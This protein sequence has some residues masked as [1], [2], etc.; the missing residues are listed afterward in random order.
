MPP[1]PAP[2][3]TAPP[4]DAA[5]AGPPVARTV[6]VDG[7]P[8]RWMEG[9][10]NAERDA[11]LRA[12]GKHAA[13]ELAK[14]P[15]RDALR[16]RVTELGMGVGAVFGVSRAGD[17]LFYYATPA[18]ADLARLMVRDKA[19]DRVLVDPAE[20]ATVDTHYSLHAYSPSP[21][22][23]LVA[24]VTS[25]GG[26]EIG[27]LHVIDPATRR[28]LPETI[29]RIWGE[30]SASWLPDGKSFFYT[31]LAAD[32][33]GDALANQ[34]A[35]LHVLGTPVEHDVE[36]LPRVPT[37]TLAL[38]PE[39]WPGLWAPPGSGVVLAFVGGAH[40]EQ[41][42][43]VAKLAELDRSGAGK[44]PWKVLADYK[45]GVESAVVHGDRIY[46]QSYAGAPNRRVLSV[47]LAHP[48]LAKARVE[49]AESPDASLAGIW[50]ARDALYV[51]RRDNGFAT[52]LR[53]P[54]R[55]KAEPLALPFPAWAPD[56]ASDPLRDGLVFQLEGW[57]APGSY[58]AYDAKT[59]KVA[60]I[61][62]AS[63]ATGDFSS[64]VADELE[65]SSADGTKVP[66]TV[67]HGKDLA[68]DH[69]HPTVVY[70][71]GAYGA[72]QSPGFSAT[73]LAWIER[74]GVI[75]IAHVRGG[76][77]R[78]RKWQDDG[79]RD[80]KLNG[81]QDVIACAEELVARGYTSPAKLAA[82]GGSMGGLLI[83]RVIT[84][85]PDLFAAA[86]VGVGFVNPSR[87][88]FAE[89]GPNQKAELGDPATP[90][91]ARAL[92]E[93]DAYLHV[94]RAAYP[95]T[96]FTVGLHD[97]RVAPWMSAK[98]A[99][100][101]LALST[102]RR[103]I[104]VRVDVDAGHGHGSTREQTFA[105]RADVWSFFLAAFTAR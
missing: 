55:G 39:E 103:P 77:E 27:T 36:V 59:K 11:W 76:G 86:N 99:A 62:L 46:V 45:D 52:I 35:K 102:S 82:Q 70:A 66:L 3:V 16:A 28:A 56:L 15:G 1:P 67:L 34:V 31:Q 49:L 13:A 61:G 90:E 80:K 43:A 72:S 17:R 64:I 25:P 20:L 23:S 83:G 4:P 26:S 91:G 50:L 74:G 100:R 8:Y 63:T 6:D 14:L 94:S 2:V 54:W 21:D 24:Y 19:G 85:R 32:P 53:W 68:L 78:G 98:M 71:Y 44:T 38:A 40:S 60:P 58:F 101:M 42:I 51:L 84:E 48:E 12:Q 89:N 9:T 5:P 73:R 75:A 33:H 47:P 87:L 104:L 10:D 65:A 88:A 57:L 69:S 79:S 81:V 95:A 105:E 7:D 18:G 22:G 30:G 97:H 93:M 37:A 29:E 96:I 92:A 41:R